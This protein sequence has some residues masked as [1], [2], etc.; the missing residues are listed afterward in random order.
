M[1]DEEKTPILVSTIEVNKL[2]ERAYAR[3]WN[4]CSFVM[5][6]SISQDKMEEM[7]P[8]VLGELLK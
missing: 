8:H 1:S 5:H 6:Q 4:D 7:V 3:G 2:V